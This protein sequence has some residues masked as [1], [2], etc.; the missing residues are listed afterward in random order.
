MPDFDGRLNQQDYDKI[1]EWFRSKWKMP[2]CPVCNARNSW[3][4]EQYLANAPIL[5]AISS[6]QSNTYPFVL[7]ICS[8]CGHTVH[9]NAVSIG[10]AQGA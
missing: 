2:V 3:S 10:I 4:V 5:R 9:M 8:N 1:N 7:V 6:Q